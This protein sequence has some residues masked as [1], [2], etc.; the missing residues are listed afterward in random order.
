[1]AQI[2]FISE[3]SEKSES[4]LRFQNEPDLRDSVGI[5]PFRD[6]MEMKMETFEKGKTI[7]IF[8]ILDPRFAAEAINIGRQNFC[9]IFA[10]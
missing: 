8:D 7:E 5:C 6:M 2:F 3:K 4:S 9:G 1:M 10:I